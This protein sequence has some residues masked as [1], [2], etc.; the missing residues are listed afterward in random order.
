MR[1]DI[2]INLPDSCEDEAR[3][4]RNKLLMFRF[5]NWQKINPDAGA[6][7]HIATAR[8]A[9][10]F[11]PLLAMVDNDAARAAILTYAQKSQSFLKAFRSH[12]CEEQVLSVIARLMNEQTTLSIKAITQGYRAQYGKEH[13]NP[14]TPK[15]IGGILRSKLHLSAVKRQ[16]VYILLQSEMP[17]INALLERYSVKID[18]S[19][20]EKPA[21]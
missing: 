1:K 4:L 9:Q 7:I 16:G 13:L 6:N 21:I 10:V 19:V 12:S 18:S 5:K 17:K 8:T 3:A 2:P 14:I 20:S 11:R 15:W